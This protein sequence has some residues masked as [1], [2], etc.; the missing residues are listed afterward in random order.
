[1]DVWRNLVSGL[2]FL[3][4][5]PAG[6]VQAQITFDGGGGDGFVHSCYQQNSPQLSNGVIYQGGSADGFDWA[7]Y[8]QSVPV[9]TNGQVY[10]GGSGD[11]FDWNCYEQSVPVLTNGQ[12]YEGG[13]GDGFDWNCY[14]QSVPMLTNGQVYEGGSGDG[15]DWA[16]YEQSVPMLTNTFIFEGGDADGF[17]CFNLGNPVPVPLPVRLLNFN[18]VAVEQGNH[19]TWSFQ[20][21]EAPRLRLQRSLDGGSSFQTVHSFYYAADQSNGLV[22]QDYL[23]GE[24]PKTQSL[25]LYRLQVENTDGSVHYFG[26]VALVRQLEGQPQLTVYP[27]PLPVAQ[28]AHLLMERF[29]PGRYH[30]RVIDLKGR[31]V[32][33]KQLR[34]DRSAENYI[35]V[36]PKSLQASTYMI[37]LNHTDNGF[38]QTVK[39]LIQK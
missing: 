13:S 7:C 31:S 27:N 39:L 28:K 33:H 22:K 9:L 30:L 35:L 37:Q 4:C 19:I 34:L 20:W 29:P 14:E 6:Q 8:E 17:A 32:F 38:E 11:G 21:D 2:F 16:C 36:L 5:F 23:D 12:V 25:F 10:K 15:F 26:P 3:C 24:W 1:M 18:A